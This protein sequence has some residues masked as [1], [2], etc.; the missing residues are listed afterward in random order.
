MLRADTGALHAAALGDAGGL[1]V[2]QLVV[3]IGNPRG[4]AASVTAGVGALGRSLPVGLARRP[5]GSSRTSCRP[6]PR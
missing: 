3:A 6:T 2:G 5:S 1:R 4:S